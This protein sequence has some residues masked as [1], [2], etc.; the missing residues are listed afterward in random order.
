M[1][2]WK[3]LASTNSGEERKVRSEIEGIPSIS[4]QAVGQFSAPASGISD[5]V[6]SSV[7]YAHL[8][9]ILFPVCQLFY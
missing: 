8:V 4:P 5:G 7:Q 3:A 9:N 1:P 2:M 6:D